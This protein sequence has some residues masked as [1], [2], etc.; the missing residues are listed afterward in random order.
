MTCWQFRPKQSGTDVFTFIQSGG[1]FNV[2]IGGSSA[3]DGGTHA[4]FDLFSSTSSFQMSGG[5]LNVY[6]PSTGSSNVFGIHIASSSGNY[7]VTGGTVQV[8]T[9]TSNNFNIDS[10]APFY[11]LVVNRVSGTSTARLLNNSLTI[12]NN[13]TINTGSTPT[14]NTNSLNL[15]VGGNINVQASTTFTASGST[16]LTLN[17][18]GAQTWTTSGT[19]TVSLNSV[20]VNKSAGTVTLSGTLPTIPTLTLTSGT[21][22]DGGTTI[23]VSTAI[24]NSATHTGSGKI[25]VS[26]PTAIGGANG[27]FGNL[28]IATDGTV[29]T[30]GD[31]T[32][33]GTLRLVATNSTI[34]IG[35]NSLTVNAITAGVGFGAT[36]RVL[37]NGLRNDGGFTLQGAAGDVLFPVGTTVAAYSPITINVAATTHGKITVRPV[38][39]AHPN[40]VATGKSLGYFW[41]VSSVSY[42][43]ITAVTHKSYS[44]G[45][46]TLVNGTAGEKATYSPA[47]FDASSNSWTYRTATYDAT[48]QTAIPNFDPST[49]WSSNAV[50]LDGEYT[51]GNS[52]AFIPSASWKTF[53]SS[54]NTFDWTLATTWSTVAVG[55]STNPSSQTPCAT[56]PV[57]IGDASHNHTVFIPTATPTNCGS[58]F[59]AAG[60]TLDCRNNTLLNFGVNTSGTGTLRIAT[61]TF[62]A[63][64][65]VNFLKSGGGT[66]EWYTDATFSSSYGIPTTGSAPQSLSLV[67]YNNLSI[68][69]GTG[70]VTF[71]ALNLTIYGNLTK[72]GASIANT[73]GSARTITVNGNFSVSGGSFTFASTAAATLSVAGDITVSAGATL[74][75]PGGGAIAHSLSTT[76]SI[77]NDG[78]IL[79][80]SGSTVALTCTGSSNTTISGG[81]SS[82]TTLYTLNVNKGTSQTPTLTMNTTGSVTAGTSGWLTLTNGT[83]VMNNSGTFN[84]STASAAY[85]IPKTAKLNVQAGTVNIV[86]ANNTAADLS[87]S[88]ALEV[89]G[90]TVNVGNS[91]NTIDNDIEYAAAGTPTITISSGSL[92]V[93]GSIRRSTATIVGAL[94]YNQTGG[95]VTVRGKSVTNSRGIFEIEY[96]T[97][98][99]FTQTGG[100]LTIERPTNG[101]GNYADLYL[102]PVSSNVTSGGTINI[103]IGSSASAFKLNIATNIG[104]LAFTASSSTY[105][106]TLYS[107]PISILNNLTIGGNATLAT[108]SL[109]VSIAGNLSGT[110]TYNGSNNT[111]TFNGTGAQTAA[112]TAA[113]Q[114]LNMA[115]NKTAGTTVALSG[116]APTLNNLNILSGI[117]DVGSL[118]LTVNNNIINN[119]SQIGAGS[120]TLSGAA[121]AH[122]I[123]SSGGSFT[124]LSL[125]GSAASKLVTVSGNLTINGTLDFTA[126]GTSRYFF[127][128]SSLLTFGSGAAISNAGAT[129]FIKTNGV[130][131]DLGVAKVWQSGPAASFTYTVGT[132]TN[133]TPV[134]FTNLVVNTTGTYTVLPVDD[135]HPTASPNG[136]QILNYYWVLKKDNTL[137]HNATGTYV[138]Q[139]PTGLVG[140]AGGSLIGAYFDAINLVGWTAGGVVSTASGNTLLTFTGSFGTVLPGLNGEFN[141]TFGTVNTLPNPVTPVYSRFADA[142]GVSNPSTVGTLGTGGSWATNTSWTLSSNGMGAAVGSVP[143]NRP[144]VILS[145]ARI[146][147][148]VLG[149]RAFSTQLSG[150]L[151]VTTAGHSI[152]AI[153][154][155]GTMRTTISTLPSGTYTS[156][157]N[158]G[159]GTIEYVAPMTMNSRSTYNNLSILSSSSGTVT[160]TNTDLVIN[161]N[162]TVPSASITLDNSANNRNISIAGNW[163]NSGTFTPGTG[164]VTFAGSSTQTITGATTFYGLTLNNA[165]GLTLGS[166]TTVNGP[167]TLTNGKIASNNYP[168]VPLLQ[169]GST[170][171]TLGGSASSFVSGQIRK[172]MLS[173]SSFTFPVGSTSAATYRPVGIGTTSANDVWDVSYINGDPT[174]AGYPFDT[175]NAANMALV[176]QYEYWMVAPAGSASASLT[177]SFGAGSYGGADIGDPTKLKTVRWDG[178]QWDI[179]PGGGTFSQ[180]GSAVAG[181]V[182]N[183]L[184]TAFSPQTLATDD[185]SS[186]LPITLVSF[187]AI[188]T[189]AGVQVQWKTVQEINNERFEV[190]RSTNGLEFEVVGTVPGAGNSMGPRYY[191]HM[192]RTAQGSTRYYYRLRQIDYDG[193]SSLSKVVSVNPLDASSQRW[194]VYPN[195]VTTGADLTIE[196]LSGATGVVRVRIFTA[197]GKTLLEREGSIADLARA[198]DELIRNASASLFFI[199]ILDQDRGEVYKIM[200]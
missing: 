159:G 18:S 164:T 63:G 131:S 108:N 15:S 104:S 195:P 153:T 165:A 57:V 69:A 35:S 167:L 151:V 86:T 59:V 101:T 182:T 73:A 60:S 48:A 198:A 76:G 93:N 111:T 177:L 10:T 13:L 115:V 27:T 70:A 148:D 113:S 199:Q 19:A 22:N 136:E 14:F 178:T 190:E 81:L 126:S 118:A 68:N 121:T 174:L 192:D 176:S 67:N 105:T 12:L 170:A 193:K 179:A 50:S 162:L 28:D 142:D 56:C 24:S 11:N 143:S 91:A 95:A 25:S 139:A 83:F 96:N 200:R 26:G 51:A 58:L 54:G 149:Q 128:G 65:F 114:F 79:F 38:K 43:A 191:Q 66:I 194:L 125:G 92:N 7:N 97:G 124:N 75:V 181:T 4:R 154:G 163:N 116:S 169:L 137:A 175:F 6:V 41:R 185:P 103:G 5:T 102:N 168:A 42:S 122:S 53:Y 47:R 17:G 37:T 64:D 21:L 106:S 34:S 44:Y 141:Y 134:I 72:S 138:V 160:M 62:P 87:L 55:S 130:S 36:S 20:V 74:G 100:S 32:C 146:N 85:N 112:L 23:T 187:E 144:V 183:S 107:N 140:G 135:Q 77:I 82:T 132:R 150:L 1:T 46:S 94:V 61:G 84:L 180:T 129:R 88:G 31:Q 109:D 39:N 184:Q 127:I 99:S 117:L 119:S 8:Y 110:G 80:L 161:G 2:G 45:S 145:G 197:D 147:L 196:D 155:T 16:V 172:T 186:T 52:A 9:S 71:P 133:Y 98:S 173:G 78:T 33:T 40:V 90:G 158:T 49:G 3:V 123:T 29:T 152:G 89:A 120:V 156:F 166:T 30:S 171:T 188:R 189:L 157:T